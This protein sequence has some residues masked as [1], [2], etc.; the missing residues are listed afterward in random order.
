MF[1]RRIERSHLVDIVHCVG[2]S[3]KLNAQEL[4]GVVRDKNR[5]KWKGMRGELK[6]DREEV[7]EIAE[8][9]AVM[10]CLK[11]KK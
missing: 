2:S 9:T 3:W 7:L 4:V 8:R 5:V 10:T 6:E 11:G 1:G